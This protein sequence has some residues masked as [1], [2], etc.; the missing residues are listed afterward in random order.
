[1]ENIFILI[2]SLLLF[3]GLTMKFL[4]NKVSQKYVKPDP[5]SDVT[6]PA[7][8]ENFDESKAK[9]EHFEKFVVS[10]FD[11]GFFIIN[12]WRSD[13]IV[14]GIYAISNH[15]PDLEIEFNYRTKEIKATFAVECKYRK[16]FYQNNIE[17][18][19]GYQ[20]S[21]Y[22]KYA[23]KINIPV[24]I[25]IGVGGQA[26]NPAELFVIPLNEVNNTILSSDFLKKYQKNIERKFYWDTETK[27]LK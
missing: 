15:F 25:V 26:Q 3:T 1:M 20:L 10:K 19:A 22:K 14:N 12:E 24:F 7:Q 23:D 6:T 11:T 2:G 13:K 16:N 4:H 9:G 21:N 17:W 5:I 18:A 27:M 8:N